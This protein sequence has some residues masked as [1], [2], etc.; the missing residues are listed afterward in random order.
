MSLNRAVAVLQEMPLFRNLDLKRLRVV[1][2]MG[3]S[4]A[5]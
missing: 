1:A 5:Y 3:E 2:M 4:Q